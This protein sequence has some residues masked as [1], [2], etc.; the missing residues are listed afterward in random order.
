VSWVDAVFFTW[1]GAWSVCI[2]L[3]VLRTWVE[4]RRIRVALTRP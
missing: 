3:A 1:W 4:L 2:L